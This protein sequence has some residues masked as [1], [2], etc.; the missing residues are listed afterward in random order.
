EAAN[1]RLA[2]H[3]QALESRNAMLEHHTEKLRELDAVKSRFFANISYEFRTPLTLILGPL[4]DAM[5]DADGS[6][7]LAQYVE[8]MHRN[9]SNLLRFINELLDFAKL[10]SGRMSLRVRRMDVRTCITNTV[11]AFSSRAARRNIE[12]QIAL[13][14]KPLI[15]YADEEKL[16][17]IVS[18]LIS[19][20]FKFTPKGGSI[21]VACELDDADS[22]ISI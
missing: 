18:N 3:E 13:P 6:G 2:E 5:N 9:A 15:L 11:A 7:A 17:R 10:E 1:A 19:N 21:R 4:D 20:A 16:E 8:P 12:L 22:A 14:E